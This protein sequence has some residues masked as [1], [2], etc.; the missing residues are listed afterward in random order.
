MGPFVKLWNL[1]KSARLTF[2]STDLKIISFTFSGNDS[3]V[4]LERDSSSLNFQ[5]CKNALGSILSR[6][7]LNRILR[8]HMTN[9]FLNLV[10][11]QWNWVK[12]SLLN[13]V[14][15]FLFLIAHSDVESAVNAVTWNC[16]NIFYF[17]S[18]NIKFWNKRPSLINAS[19]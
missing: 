8:T 19:L 18:W 1:S 15:L 7:S 11:W 16:V 17:W 10:R 9:F 6:P 14:K 12:I 2:Q 3:R 13:Y 4:K 5:S